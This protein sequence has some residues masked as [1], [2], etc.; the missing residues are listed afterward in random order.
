MFSGVRRQL[1]GASD[2]FVQLLTAHTPLSFKHTHTLEISH[3]TLAW[4][5]PLP[6]DEATATHLQDEAGPPGRSVVTDTAKL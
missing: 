3:L 6:G 1:Q 4:L 2:K 5:A